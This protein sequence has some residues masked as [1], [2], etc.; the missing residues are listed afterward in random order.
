MP[1]PT[2]RAPASLAPVFIMVELIAAVSIE[3]RPCAVG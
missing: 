2:G 1:S 3:V